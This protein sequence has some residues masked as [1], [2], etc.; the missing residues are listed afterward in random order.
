MKFAKIR[1]VKSPCRGTSKSAGID[2]FVPNYSEEFLRVFIEK[3]P[4][5]P[6]DNEG[7]YVRPHSR[8]LIPSGI[9]CAVPENYGLIAFNKSGVFTKSGLSVGACV[10][11]CDYTGEIHLSLFNS[12]NDSTKILWG[13]KIIQ[14]LLVPIFFDDVEEIDMDN[15][16]INFESERK[17]AG[18]G[19]T[20]I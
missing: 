1:D 10:V 14:F 8:V 16:F 19:S 5:C 7:F 12:T 18:F 17:D 6:N 13:Q 15:L 3:N 20:G 2:F 11:D 4:A 9:K